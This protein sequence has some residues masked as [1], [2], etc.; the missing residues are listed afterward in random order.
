MNVPDRRLYASPQRFEDAEF[1]LA[2]CR[3]RHLLLLCS[4]ILYYFVGC[5]SRE[6]FTEIF[7]DEKAEARKRTMHSTH[8]G[9]RA[10]APSDLETGYEYIIG[11]GT[12][13]ALKRINST[14]RSLC[15][16]STVSVDRPYHLGDNATDRIRIHICVA[17]GALL[18]C[19]A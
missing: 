4:Y 19:F 8:S 1:E 13:S 7:T 16:S 10:F 9:C 5:R 15:L 2:E 3:M 12:R 14:S 6:I 18:A 17:A 11:A